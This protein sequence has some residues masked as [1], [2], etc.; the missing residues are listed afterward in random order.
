MTVT[1]DHADS[2]AVMLSMDN[3]CIDLVIADPPYGVSYQ[4]GRVKGGTKPIAGDWNFQAGDFFRAIGRVL[5]PGGAAYIFTRWDVFPIWAQAVHGSQLK[6][7][8]LIVWVK[9]NHTAGDLTGNFGF[10]WEGIMLL[11]KGR[12]VIRGERH[13]NVWYADRVTKAKQ[14]HPA[15]KPVALV[16][17]AIESRPSSGRWISSIL[18]TW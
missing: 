17:R 7:K 6:L 12:H 2:M 1:Y 18:W 15:E 14:L 5:K 9:N 4:S 8:N 10:K 16:R 13:S 11:T 3:E